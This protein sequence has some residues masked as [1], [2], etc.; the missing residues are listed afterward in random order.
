MEILKIKCNSNVTSNID[1]IALQRGPIVYCAEGLDN[2]DS[3]VLDLVI[4]EDKPMEYRFEENNFN[5]IMAIYGKANKTLRKKDGSIELGK[6]VDVKAIPYYAWAHRTPSPM[7][8]WFPVNK[9]ATKP[10]PAKTIA[11][12]SKIGGSVVNRDIEAIRDQ[13]LPAG[14]NDK[15]Y[16][17]FHWWPSANKT[18]WITY[19]FDKPYEISKCKIFWF[20]DNGGCKAPKSWKLLYK[21]GS[22]WKEVKNKN[23]YG[24]QLD[25]INI[26]DF[27]PIVASAVKLEVD[28]P[29]DCSSGIHEWII[30]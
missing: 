3:S 23:Q 25:I 5:G 19:D 11:N 29:A 20:S 8:I 22:E 6:E 21:S 24:V 4:S 16:Q 30:E 2:E 9:E 15:N 12:L 7:V 26:T 1:K 14:S 13:L 27:E 18:E 10:K 17:F 28:L